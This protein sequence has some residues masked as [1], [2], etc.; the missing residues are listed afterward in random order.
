MERPLSLVQTIS[1]LIIPGRLVLI[2]GALGQ[3]FLMLFFHQL[4][5]VWLVALRVV[6]VQVMAV[7]L[8]AALWIDWPF[9][10]NIMWGPVFLPLGMLEL[11][12]FSWYLFWPRGPKY[13][14]GD[15]Q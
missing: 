4:K 15:S 11:A 1:N 6:A 9:S 12:V 3:F 5:E 13:N 10:F 7:T 8:A 2:L 14:K